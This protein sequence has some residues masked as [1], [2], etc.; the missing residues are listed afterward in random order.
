M[1]LETTLPP[2]LWL[3]VRVNY[4]K[5]NFTGAIID[6]FHYLTALLREKSGVD[7]DGAKLIGD[8]LNV[9]NPKIKLNK[10]QTQSEKDAQRGMAEMLRGL[11][12]NIRNPRSHEKF[13]DN[14]EDTQALLVFMGYLIRR[15]DQAKPPF[16]RAEFVAR[17]FDPHFVPQARYAEGLVA[18]IPLIQRLDVFLEVYAA[19]EQ[20]KIEHLRYLF[21]ALL[22]L[23]TEEERK[24]VYAVISNELKKTIHKKTI[25]Y[26]IG[27]LGKK[28]WASLDEMARIRIEN[29]L[30][31]TVNSGNFGYGSPSEDMLDDTSLT[32]ILS[33]FTLKKEF[34]SVIVGKLCSAVGERNY[35]LYHFSYKDLESLSDKMPPRL[36]NY[37]VRIF[38]AGDRDRGA[39]FHE[40]LSR[41]QLWEKSWSPEL[42][43]A[44]NDFGAIP[45]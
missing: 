5:R 2:A 21:D 34:L 28:D 35:V 19:K 20:G 36:D 16:S 8:A 38:S 24:Q 41:V 12:S 39:A 33:T 18:E 15:I 23:L 25:S 30:I 32:E 26:V 6:G 29:I 1:N 40:Y 17:V 45:Y 43:K 11:Y 7:G 14:E 42:V 9:D 31:R 4:E 44:F 22:P 37:L 13:E 27:I 3:A 10:L